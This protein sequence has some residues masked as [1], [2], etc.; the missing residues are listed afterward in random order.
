MEKTIKDVRPTFF[1]DP[2]Q[3]SLSPGIPEAAFQA[4]HMNVAFV[5]NAIQT[6]KS[7]AKR[8]AHLLMSAQNGFSQNAPN[9]PSAGSAL[10]T[11]GPI[12][13]LWTDAHVFV[14][15]VYL[16]ETAGVVSGNSGST[17]NPWAATR[18]KLCATTDNYRN[19]DFCES[20]LEHSVKGLFI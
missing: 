5:Q 17:L 10:A 7:L 8:A 14:D 4:G 1:S 18:K 16:Q 6:Q 20:A 2:A 3:K 13:E 11:V 19:V 15:D 12:L 9:Q